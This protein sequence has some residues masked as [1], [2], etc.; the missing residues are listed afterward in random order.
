MNKDPREIYDFSYS[1]K[2]VHTHEEYSELRQVTSIA[3][4]CKKAA[5]IYRIKDMEQGTHLERLEMV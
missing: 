5:L 3:T 4:K 1:H 2:S